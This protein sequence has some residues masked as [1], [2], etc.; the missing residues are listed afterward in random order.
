VSNT[1]G[2]VSNTTGSIAGDTVGSVA[3]DYIGLINIIPD[4]PLL[5]SNGTNCTNCTNCFRWTNETTGFNSTPSNTQAAGKAYAHDACQQAKHCKPL[6][7]VEQ[8]LCECCC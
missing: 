2:N 1:T 3:V 7:G 4:V 5:T 8:S 6:A